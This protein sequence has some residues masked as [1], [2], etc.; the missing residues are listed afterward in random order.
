MFVWLLVLGVAASLDEGEGAEAEEG[1]GR[2]FGDGFE[3]DG[4]EEVV[5]VVADFSA[6]GELVGGCGGGEVVVELGP[7]FERLVGAGEDDGVVEG[8]FKCSA[9]EEEGASDQIGA[10]A[11]LLADGEAG[12]SLFNTGDFGSAVAVEPVATRVAALAGVR[13]VSAEEVFDGGPTG[14][15]GVKVSVDNDLGVG[16]DGQGQD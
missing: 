10:E 5:A 13:L 11:I 12:D 8:D 16:A 14:G 9:I 6:P 2:R 7:V 15:V 3:G 1:H 4:V